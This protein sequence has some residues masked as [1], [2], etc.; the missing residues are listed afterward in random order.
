[1][2]P[3]EQ[4]GMEDGKTM[5]STEHNEDLDW[6]RGVMAEHERPLVRYACRITHD[7]E[8]A[9]D[10]VQETFLR[11]WRSGRASKGN[12]LPEWLFT[13]CRNRAIDVRRK[14]RRMT[15]TNEQPQA[16]DDRPTPA[17]SAENSDTAGA[18][19]RAVADLPAKE[20]EV[21]VLKFQNGFTYRQIA[22]I[23]GLSVS[24]VGVLIHQG[25]TKLRKQFKTLGLMDRA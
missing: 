9:R 12:H 2:I 8:R 7:L 3:G 15:L 11:L 10:V 18:A 1:V 13:V 25:I 16:S 14:E 23:T 19:M 24:H 20:Q 5:D 17:E 22:G 6:L 21:L 4:E